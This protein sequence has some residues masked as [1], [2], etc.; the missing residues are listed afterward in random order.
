[1]PSGPITTA[2]AGVLPGARRTGYAGTHARRGQIVLV[3]GGTPVRRVLVAGGFSLTSVVA[4]GLTRLFYSILIARFLA[5]GSLSDTNTV[6]SIAMFA[7]L[8]WPS[9]VANASTM[10][11]ARARGAADPALEHATTRFLKRRALQSNAALGLLAGAYSLLFFAP[12]EAL[13]AGFTFAI[14]VGFGLSSFVRGLLYATDRVPRA[15]FLDVAALLMALSGLAVVIRMRADDLLLLPLA[16]GYAL[17]IVI[18]WPRSD[19]TNGQA[20]RREIDRFVFW[21]IA[22]MVATGGFLQLTMIIAHASGTPTS[23]DLYA[24]ALTLATPAAMLTSVVSLV[25]FPSLARLVGSGDQSG[26]QRQTDLAMRGLAAVLV[27]AFGALTLLA[28]PLLSVIYGNQFSGASAILATLLIASLL[29]AL[30]GPAADALGSRTAGG[31]RGLAILRVAGFGIGLVAC[32]TLGSLLGALGV[33]LGYLVGMV[34][35]GLGSIIYAWR[36]LD[37]R[38][39]ALSARFL[40]GMVLLAVLL[41][42]RDLATGTAAILGLTAVFLAG[43]ALISLPDTRQLVRLGIRP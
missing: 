31:I 30:S 37:L 28:P 18:G 13:T 42:V 22:G 16:S 39:G 24:A 2:P 25:L 23:S 36:R 4:Q 35:A 8:L 26:A 19:R 40:A 11:V 5:P 34:V 1:M 33:A 20:P 9:S 43:W 29:G 32:L 17:I 21:G 14:V 10:F 15:A 27:A 7:A 12:G 6:I 3:V 41:G 38:W